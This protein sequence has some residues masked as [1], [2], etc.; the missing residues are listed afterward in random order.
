M[1][2]IFVKKILG[3]AALLLAISVIPTLAVGTNGSFES[4]D[5]PGAYTTLNAGDS[6]SITDWMVA[7]GSV[8][9]IGTYWQ[10]SNGSRSIDLNGLAQGSITQ[11][12]PT[13]VGATYDITFDLSGNPDSRSDVNDPLYSPSL[14]DVAV[15]ATGASA[16][17]F[18]FD[19]SMKGNGLANMMWKPHTYTFVAT[20]TNTV[21]AFASQIPGAFGPALDNVLI[22]ETALAPIPAS[23][24]VDTI[25]VF[26]ETKAIDSASQAP[27][28]SNNS[29]ANGQNYLLVS[30][31]A[32]QNSLN[33]ADTEYTSIDNWATHMNG[34]DIA[35]YF[36]GEGEFDLQI[37]GAFVDWGAYSPTHQYSYLYMGIGAPVNL[38]VFDGDSNTGIVNPGWY[39]DNSGSLT[40]DI[41]SCTPN[42]PPPP[43]TGTISGEKYNDLNR[44][45]KK[46]VGEPGLSGWV[47]KLM[48]DN[49]TS[50][51][52]DTI[53]ATTTTDGNGN[54]TFANI[55]PGTYDVR[56]VHQKGWRRMSKNPKDIVITG[57]S[58][59]TDVDFG[60]ATMRRGEKENTDK[61]DNHDDQLG[62]YYAGHGHSNYGEDYD[63]IDHAH[64][65]NNN[66]GHDDNRGNNDNDNGH[67]KSS[68]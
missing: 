9:Y 43:K 55:A 61:D 28:S 65:E 62:N 22:T 12:I 5:D 58:V 32:W 45:G 35:P 27:T 37:N 17:N 50:T 21:L 4:G 36:L 18:T 20:A 34:Y 15:I 40:V 60:N 56:E 39:G 46:D 8:D 49:G 33:V 24:P 16:Q 64:P 51:D 29:L 52:T 54:Y 3:A 13:T 59:V 63:K 2:K 38:L 23:C 6:T 67:G 30:S 10:A 25:P 57:G 44:N 7:S 48:L 66:N 53:I 31:G 42:T 26:L 47:I 68:K 41:Y 1:K 11:T 19:T 14:K